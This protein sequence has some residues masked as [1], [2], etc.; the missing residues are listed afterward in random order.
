MAII[1][2]NRNPSRRELAWFGA[3]FM[4][5]FA[6]IGGVIAWRFSGIAVAKWMWGIAALITAVYY[7]L[8]PVRRPLYLG[9][10]YAAYP[11]GWVISHVLLALIY[12][13]V[14]TPIGFIMR[15]IGHDPLS[16]KY[17]R[18]ASTYWIEH[19]PGGDPARYFR[20]F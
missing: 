20:Q 1:E 15:S 6:I 5:F 7:A 4:L 11:I 13:L 14:F 17:D 8:P 19:R 9:W 18:A 10:M 2:I 16:R 12:Y 3:L